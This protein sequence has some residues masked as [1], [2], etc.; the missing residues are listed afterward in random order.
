[1]AAEGK[2]YLD[3]AILRQNLHEARNVIQS[4]AGLPEFRRLLYF[5]RHRAEGLEQGVPR[6]VCLFG[7]QGFDYLLSSMNPGEVRF[8]FAKTISL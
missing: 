2:G 6:F 1:M 4:V 3:L 7:D 8:F 5:S